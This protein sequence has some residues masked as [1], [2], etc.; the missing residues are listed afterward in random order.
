VRV[1]QGYGTADLGC[2]A[3]ECPEKGG[4]HIHPEAIVELLDPASGQPTSPGQPGEV[5]ATIFDDAYPLVR[6]ATGDLSTLAPPARCPCGRTA[7]K[8]AGLL[9]RVGD[10]VKV[11]GMFVRA[12]QMDAVMKRF[13]AVARYRAVVTR[14]GQQDHLAYEVELSGPDAGAGDLA[15]RISEALREEVKVRGHVDIVPRG[16]LPEGAKRLED[17]RVWK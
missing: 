7:P 8:L 13:P 5:V 11:K 16:T 15:A 17:R 3:Y 2:L 6:F 4:W 1:L 9:G 14:E 12:G 10:G